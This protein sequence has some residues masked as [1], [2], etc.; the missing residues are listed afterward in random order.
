MEEKMMFLKAF[1]FKCFI[2]AFILIV[3]TAVLFAVGYV[4]WASGLAYSWY[5]IEKEIF[6]ETAIFMTGL[7]KIGTIL[8]FLIPTIALHWMSCK[9]CCK[10]KTEE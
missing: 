1:F 2:V 7:L 3:F 10:K 4:D 6:I 9:C 8:L 5:G